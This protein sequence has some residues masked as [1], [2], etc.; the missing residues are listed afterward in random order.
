MRDAV[1]AAQEDRREVD[2]LH[3]APGLERRVEDRGVI[4]RRDAGVVEQHVDVAIGVARPRVRRPDLLGVGDVGLH[5]QVT[6]SVLL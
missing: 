5:E 4:G 6:R 3:P 1:L 2:V